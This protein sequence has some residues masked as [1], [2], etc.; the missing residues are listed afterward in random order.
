MIQTTNDD[1]GGEGWPGVMPWSD[2]VR[3]GEAVERVLSR[4]SATDTVLQDPEQ[5]SRRLVENYSPHR[6]RLLGSQ[7][8]FRMRLRTGTVGSIALASLSFNTEVE[9]AQ[10]P[11]ETFVLVT[12]QLSGWSDIRT[13]RESRSGG[14]G[15]V[16]VDSAT[17]HVVKRFSADSLRLHVRIDHAALGRLC[18]QLLDRSVD[19]P[20]DFN[21]VIQPGTVA[22]RRWMAMVAMLLDHA[23][24]PRQPPFAPLFQRHVEEMAMLTLLTDHQHN[25]SGR[26]DRRESAVAPRHVRA[27]EDFIAANAHEPLTLT[28]IALAAGV[29]VRTL[30][31]GFRAF[32]NTTPMK[33]LRDIRLGRARR[34]LLD[35]GK[36]RAVS[37]V[38]MRWGFVNLGRF[39]GDYSRRFGEHPSDTLRRRR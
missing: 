35:D 1:R 10:Q 5:A 16:V 12:T 36:E 13:D 14:A 17:R 8:D 24:A 20:L 37:E 29:S 3:F 9:L 2:F 25:Y 38:A 22:H 15:M 19:G 18:A 6:L 26:L 32:R 11:A 27:A 34:D 23:E 28:E 33:H 21:P 7:A 4:S 39:A 30:T 31:A